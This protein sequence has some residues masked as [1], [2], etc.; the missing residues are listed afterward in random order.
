MTSKTDVPARNAPRPPLPPRNVPTNPTG[1]VPRAPAPN[2]SDF[3]DNIPNE[4]HNDQSNTSALDYDREFERRF[5]FTPIENLPPPK[6]W[7]PQPKPMKN[8]DE[9]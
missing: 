5:H 2:L 1:T 8:A 4:R 9:N 7:K 3:T 6:P